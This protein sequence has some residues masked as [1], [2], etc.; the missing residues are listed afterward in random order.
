MIPPMNSSGMNTAVSEIVIE[1]IVNA[2][3]AR[4]FERRFE[5]ALSHLHVPHDVL[6]HHD[7]VVHH[8]ARRR[9]SAP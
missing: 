7:G 3:L 1:R 8:E 9:A 4:P 6:E 5:R 2:D